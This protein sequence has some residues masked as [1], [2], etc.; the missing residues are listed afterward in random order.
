MIS[1]WFQMLYIRRFIIKVASTFIDG[2]GMKDYSFFKAKIALGNKRS[3][4]NV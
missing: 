4:N 2:F 3:T 1:T